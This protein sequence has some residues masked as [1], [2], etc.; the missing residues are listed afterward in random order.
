[1][2][3]DYIAE[4]LRWLD[5]M[6]THLENQSLFEDENL[7]LIQ[8]EFASRWVQ[9]DRLALLNDLARKFGEEHVM[10]VLDQIISAN[11]KRDWKRTG[12]DGGNSLGRFF[13]LLWEPL[14]KNGFEYSMV[15]EGNKTT[16]C[17]TKCAIYD[18]ARKIGAEKW[19]YHLACLTDEPAVTGFND[20]V[21]FSRTR[22]LM[23]GYSDCDHCYTDHSQ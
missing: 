5:G 11:C 6:L 13:E 20:R 3:K 17:V 2:S 9:E 19:L 10:A 7:L 14:R 4:Q 1:M 15:T 16:F 22:T 18:L 23:Q 8:Q 12:Q 21:T